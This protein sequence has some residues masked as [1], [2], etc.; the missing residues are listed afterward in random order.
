MLNG[1]EVAGTVDTSHS[2][3]ARTQGTSL[4]VA[5]FAQTPGGSSSLFSAPVFN[6]CVQHIGQ[7][8]P[9]QQM[10]MQWRLQV[11]ES[12]TTLQQGQVH[13]ERS[14]T[15]LQV[16]S[17]VSTYMMSLH[18]VNQGGEIAGREK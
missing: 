4:P 2:E 11:Q 9:H 13:L 10:D 3:V 18:L 15:S 1:T 14:V 6:K 8:G 17:S 12:I 5:T 16:E 7:P